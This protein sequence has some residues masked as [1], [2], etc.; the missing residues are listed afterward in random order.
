VVGLCIYRLTLHPLAKYPG[1]LLSK[2]T[3][4]SIVFQASSGDRHLETWKEHNEYGSVV[5]IGPNVLSFNTATALKAI[6]SGRKGNVRKSDWYR[7]IDAGSKAFSLHSEID[8]SRHAF[9]RRVIDQAFSDSAVGRAESLIL[10][11]V[12]VWVDSLGPDA[13][14][15]SEQRDMKDWCNWLSF[16][17]MGDLTFGRGFGCVEKGEHRFV[18]EVV[19]EATKFVYVVRPA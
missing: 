3:D 18:P 2:I 12:K 17:M 13:G 14:E 10:K 11:N 1:P 7:T 9:R 19:M 4:W 6:Y 5:R 15:W 16:D 8:K